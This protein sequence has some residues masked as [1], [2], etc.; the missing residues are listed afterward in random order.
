MQMNRDTA[1]NIQF[2]PEASILSR[3][4]EVLRF[5][6]SINRTAQGH[7]LGRGLSCSDAYRAAPGPTYLEMVRNGAPWLLNASNIDEGALGLKVAAPG[8]YVPGA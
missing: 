8:S 3:E 6:G 1:R 4:Y 2:A 5:V 7:L